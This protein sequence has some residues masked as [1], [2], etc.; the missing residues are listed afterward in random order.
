MHA[1]I[2]TTRQQPHSLLLETSPDAD[3]VGFQHIYV[4]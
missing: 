1:D 3:Q 4:L 2:G